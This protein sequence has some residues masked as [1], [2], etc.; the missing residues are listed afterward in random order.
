VITGD[1]SKE[2]VEEHLGELELLADTAG[3]DVVSKLTGSSRPDPATF[4]W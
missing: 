3:A 1:Y 2:Q 4:N